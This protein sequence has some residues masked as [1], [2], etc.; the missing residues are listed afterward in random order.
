MHGHRE[1]V[2][3]PVVVFGWLYLAWTAVSWLSR[4]GR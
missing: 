3:L 1:V 4:R 2:G